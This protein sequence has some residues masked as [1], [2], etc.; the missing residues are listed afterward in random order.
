MVVVGKKGRGNVRLYLT[1]FRGVFALQD[2]GMT[3]YFWGIFG[4][5][6]RFPLSPFPHPLH[7]FCTRLT[8]PASDGFLTVQLLS[9]HRSAASRSASGTCEGWLVD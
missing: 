1:F 9:S 7:T 2:G 6:R 8:T 4:L 5:P 3:G